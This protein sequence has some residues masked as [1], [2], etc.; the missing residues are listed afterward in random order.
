MLKKIVRKRRKNQ[1][2]RVSDRG[3][4]GGDQE[5]TKEKQLYGSAMKLVYYR[6]SKNWLKSI[7]R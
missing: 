1:I 3:I 4:R 2:G 5:G 7:G 6:A